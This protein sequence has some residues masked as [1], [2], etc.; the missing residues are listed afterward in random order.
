MSRAR[1]LCL[2]FLLASG[3]SVACAA[4][5]E[6]ESQTEGDDGSFAVHIAECGAPEPCPVMSWQEY[7]PDNPPATPSASEYACVFDVLSERTP[8]LIVTSDGCEGSCS[9][10]VY[11]VRSD[12]TALKQSW[13]DSVSGDGDELAG[14]IVDFGDWATRGELCQLRD[15][16]FYASCDAELDGDCDRASEW[17]ESCEPI[18]EQLCGLE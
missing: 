1:V 11:L 7:G 5:G 13:F 15:A 14:S 8:A 6:A 10:D 16:S 2:G 3:L 4:D 18:T 9:G 12:G 17:F